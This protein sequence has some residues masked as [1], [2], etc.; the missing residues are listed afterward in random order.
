MGRELLRLDL[1]RAADVLSALEDGLASPALV[2]VVGEIHGNPAP[3]TLP[4][5][6]ALPYAPRRRASPAG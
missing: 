2:A 3:W 4:P 5:A 1:S 6:A